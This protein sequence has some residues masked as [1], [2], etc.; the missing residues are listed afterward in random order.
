[1][2]NA[3][4][5][6]VMATCGR[7]RFYNT[8]PTLRQVPVVE[9]QEDVCWWRNNFTCECMRNYLGNTAR[10]RMH[11][12]IGHSASSQNEGLWT[13]KNK[14]NLYT[15]VWSIEFILSLCLARTF[16]FHATRWVG[17]CSS[18][19]DAAVATL[20]SKPIS[21]SWRRTV[22]WRE[23][24][25]LIPTVLYL[26]GRARHSDEDFLLSMRPYRGLEW[27]IY[28]R[29]TNRD[30]KATNSIKLQFCVLTNGRW[31]FQK[32][33]KPSVV[34][35]LSFKEPEVVGSFPTVVRT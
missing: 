8:F 35:N 32:Y 20:S 26:D 31:L 27:R 21:N 7:Q 10:Q 19:C 1:M 15:F 13:I 17:T 9:T 6:V 5:I 23:L 11:I 34:L 3:F 4:Q 33:N 12:R 24:Q 28:E 18:H 29:T 22:W 30:I 2:R 16:F 14:W 25:L